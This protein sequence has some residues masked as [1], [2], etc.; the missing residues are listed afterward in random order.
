[1]SALSFLNFLISGDQPRQHLRDHRPR[2]HDG[3]RHCENA[4]LRPRRRHHGGRVYLLFCRAPSLISPPI[5][6][7]ILGHDRLHRARHR[8]S[9]GWR[10][11][12]C[13][14]APSLAVLITAIGVSYFLQNAALLL[15]GSSPVV[16]PNFFTSASGRD[17]LCPLRRC[18]CVLSYVA[19]VTIAVCV[20]IMVALSLLHQQDQNGQGHARR[21]PRTRARRSSWA[22]T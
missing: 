2:L 21:A 4:E 22:S 6:G 18:S 1:M 9:N 12:R 20:V 14:T 15:W 11:S 7:V 13:A 8:R 19:L 10:I 3:L 5:V 17:R 16:F